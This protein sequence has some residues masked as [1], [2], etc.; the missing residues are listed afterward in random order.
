M[1]KAPQG[2]FRR[3]FREGKGKPSKKD[4]WDDFSSYRE[5]PDKAISKNKEDTHAAWG[6]TNRA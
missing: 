3:R 2:G 5:H 4:T 1:A 6:G